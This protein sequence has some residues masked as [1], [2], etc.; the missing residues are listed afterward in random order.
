MLLSP[1]GISHRRHAFACLKDT[2]SS[3]KC[4]KLP[5]VSRGIQSLPRATVVQKDFAASAT[6][7]SARP[8]GGLNAQQKTF[9]KYFLTYNATKTDTPAP[10][11]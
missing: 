11:L 10:R 4:S 2:I 7:G 3:L 8:P 6:D 9:L 5:S 1:V